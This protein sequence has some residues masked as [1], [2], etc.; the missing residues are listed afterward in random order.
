MRIILD[1][2]DV[3]C[4]FEGAACRLH[5]VDPKAMQE[6]RTG[7]DM[8]PF[9][10]QVTG[11]HMDQ[12]GFWAPIDRAGETFWATLEAHEWMDELIHLV[13]SITDDWHIVSSPSLC[14]S[15]YSGKVKWLKRH[16]GRSFTNFALTPHK[17]IFSQEG[18]L[19]IDD[20][21]ENV[22]RFIWAVEGVESLGGDGLVFPSSG[23]SLRALRGDPVSHIRE[24]LAKRKESD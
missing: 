20:R 16:L 19:L 15:S 24:M 1:L 12:A 14:P 6:V 22:T 4:D 5:G 18:V 13:K 3:L 21:E 10:Q 2:D 23:N 11:K 7:W 17:H 9:F 8:V